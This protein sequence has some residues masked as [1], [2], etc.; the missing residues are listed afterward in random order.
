MT[1]ISIMN[2]FNSRGGDNKSN[3]EQRPSNLAPSN[4]LKQVTESS[5]DDVSSMV[6]TNRKPA[7]TLADKALIESQKVNFAD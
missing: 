3:H 6:I 2:A 4:Q 5:H 7:N 1:E